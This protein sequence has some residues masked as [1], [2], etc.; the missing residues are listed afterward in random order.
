VKKRIVWALVILAAAC[1]ISVLLLDEYFAARAPRQAHLEIG[2][3]Y[4]HVAGFEKTHVYLRSS[5]LFEFYCLMAMSG[6]FALTAAAL[7]QSWRVISK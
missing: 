2:E 4:E 1:G 7:N 5:E 3:K 6:A